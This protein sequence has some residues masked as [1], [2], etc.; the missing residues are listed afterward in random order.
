MDERIKESEA[1]LRLHKTNS[2]SAIFIKDLAGRYV[3]VN[4]QFTHLF[5]LDLESI[6]F[7]TDTEI[8]PPNEAVQ[9]RRRRPRL[10]SRAAIEVEEVAHYTKVCTPASYANFPIRQ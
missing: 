5:G 8:F 6:L 1:R 3:F 4:K 2:P 9:F 7:H 10:E